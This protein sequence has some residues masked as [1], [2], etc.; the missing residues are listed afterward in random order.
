MKQPL[1]A[2]HSSEDTVA[3]TPNNSGP[4]LQG[5]WLA[6]ARAVWIVLVLLLLANFMASIPASYAQLRTI[7]ANSTFGHCN[8][9]QPTPGNAQALQRLGLSLDT[10]A[11]YTLTLDVLASSCSWRWVP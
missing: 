4:R 2:A 6:I 11:A 8:I 3:T 7:C 9:W 1:S 10:Y 5:R